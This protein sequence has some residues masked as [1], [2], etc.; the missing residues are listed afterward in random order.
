MSLDLYL[1]T[2]IVLCLS[3]FAGCI[4]ITVSDDMTVTESIAVSGKH[5]A[6]VAAQHEKTSH[7]IYIQ[8]GKSGDGTAVAVEAAAE[9][10]AEASVPTSDP[11]PSSSGSN[12]NSDSANSDGDKKSQEHSSAARMGV[13]MSLGCVFVAAAI[14]MTQL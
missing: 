3:T 7:D 9:D 1:A 14:G 12:S 4:N 5:T 6:V 13:A 2:F 10:T 8:D 11:P